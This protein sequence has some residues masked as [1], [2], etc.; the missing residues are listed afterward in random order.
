MI[1]VLNEEGVAAKE[2]LCELAVFCQ[3]MVSEE[4]QSYL[5]SWAEELQNTGLSYRSAIHRCD[6]LQQEIYVCDIP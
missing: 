6:M 4:G 5:R 2:Q 3:S 1:F